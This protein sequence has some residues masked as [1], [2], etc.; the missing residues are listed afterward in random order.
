MLPPYGYRKMTSKE[1]ALTLEQRRTVGHP[2][3]SPPHL[4]RGAG[5][6]TITVANYEHA[7]VMA[8]PARRTELERG[9]LT[10]VGR[11]GTEVLGWVVLPNHYHMIVKVE[12][13]D[14]VSASLRRLHGATSRAWNLADRVTGKRRVWYKFFDRRLRDEAHYFAAL[15]YLHMNPVK[16]GC[17]ASPYDWAWSSVHKFLESHGREWLRRTWKVHRPSEDFGRGWDDEV[18]PEETRA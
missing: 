11:A 3:H 8:H 1:R 16:H 5:W 12:S 13:L 15:N 10:E 17:A 2:L 18:I 9:L 4:Y 7:P 14:A 6:Y